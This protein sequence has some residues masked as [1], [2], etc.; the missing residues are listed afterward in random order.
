MKSKRFWLIRPIN[1]ALILSSVVLLILLFFTDKRLAYICAPIVAVIVIVS[2]YRL[3]KIQDDLHKM[4]VELG[5]SL[6][7]SQD[8]TLVNT[9]VPTALLSETGEFIWYNDS[10]RDNVL[11]EGENVFGMDIRSL[12]GK[13]IEELAPAQ[14]MIVD[15]RSKNFRSF[16]N[17][18]PFHDGFVYM[19][20]LVDVTELQQTKLKALKS[21]PTVLL[22]IVDNYDESIGNSNEGNSARL[23]GE[24]QRVLQDEADHANGFIKKLS[25]DRYIMVVEKQGL[26]T[27]VAN[28]FSVLDRVREIETENGVPVTISIGVALVDSSLSQAEQSARQALEMALGRGGDQTA[29]KTTSGYEFF[30]GFSKGV[31]KRTKVKTRMV[32]SAI[33]EMLASSGDVMIMGHRFADLDCLG[34]AIGMARACECLNKEV[35]IVVDVNRTLASDLIEK[36]NTRRQD[37]FV[38]PDIALENIT[39]DTLLLVLDTHSVNLLESRELYKKSKQ[40]IVIDHHRKLVDHID[41]AVIFYHEPYASSASE[42]VTELIQYMGDSVKVSELEAEALLAGITLDTRNFVLRTGVRTFE[43]AAYL[44]RM[45][46]DTVKVREFF[47]SEM[48][49]YQARARIVSAAEIYKECAVAVCDASIPNLRIIAPQSADEL[50]NISGVKASFV[51][52]ERDDVVSVSARSMGAYNMQIM[53]EEL[54]GGGH[55]TMAAAQVVNSDIET[56]KGKLYEIID[57]QTEYSASRD[58]QGD[59]K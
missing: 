36:V 56:V 27:M 12:V 8:A 17:K 34:A 48:N 40:V 19:L 9:P 45:G 38:H 57:R 50:L 53:M 4:L 15:C 54:G 25:H 3:F 23:I 51:L 21:K 11:D 42:M 29:I 58:N 32:A 39:A 6:T 55:H 28:R 20:Q 46:A 10:F 52:Y 35:K 14:E 31:E 44:R 24:V 41:N 13:S 26:D 1:A 5:H 30:G 18:T 2:V 47:A 49:A 22:V 7:D 37:L 33:T 16:C 59:N 43:A